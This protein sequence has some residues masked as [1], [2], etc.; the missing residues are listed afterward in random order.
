[1]TNPYEWAVSNPSMLFWYAGA[2]LFV[3]AYLFAYIRFNF[4]WLVGLND[5][6]DRTTG[7]DQLVAMPDKRMSWE[8]IGLLVSNAI[9]LVLLGGVVYALTP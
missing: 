3:L 2:A 7:R 8:I 5:S 6:W 1:M 9:M 4:R